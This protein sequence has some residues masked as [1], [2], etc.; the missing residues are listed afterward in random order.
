VI[1]GKFSSGRSIMGLDTYAS[2]AS[3]NIE[4]T[5]EDIQAFQ[6]ADIT[7]CGGLFSGNDGSFRGKVYVMLVLEITDENLTQDWIPPE[8]V[9]KMYASLLAC[10]PEEAIRQYDVDNTA[11]EILELRKFFKVCSERGLG[12]VG[13]Y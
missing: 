13:W 4:L 9:R 12:L 11:D 3:G 7:L 1:T 2:R 5:E 8:I 6:E 10:D